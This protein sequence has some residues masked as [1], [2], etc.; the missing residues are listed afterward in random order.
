MTGTG[1]LVGIRLGEGNARGVG[2]A[3]L[4]APGAVP[5][6]REGS[7]DGDDEDPAEAIG[8]LLGG[9]SGDGGND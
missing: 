4:D 6:D 7:A 2:A 1:V 3:E 9:P 5:G 8:E